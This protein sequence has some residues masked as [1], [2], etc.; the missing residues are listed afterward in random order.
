MFARLSASALAAGSTGGGEACPGPDSGG[1]LVVVVVE[2]VDDTACPGPVMVG[3]VV[4]VG[5]GGAIEA[6]DLGRGGGLAELGRL[7]ACLRFQ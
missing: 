4:L 5:L 1:E 6:L 2:V 3:I 7:E